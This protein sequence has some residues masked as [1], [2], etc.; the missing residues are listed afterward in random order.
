MKI[1]VIGYGGRG[2]LYTSILKDKHIEVEAICDTDKEKL[3]LAKRELSLPDGKLYADENEFFSKGKLVDILFVC[4]QDE[5]HYGHAIRAMK[6]GYDLLLEKPIAASVKQ[7]REIQQTAH[8]Y[9]RNVFVCHVLRYA[10]FF[11]NIK[12]QLARGKYGKVVTLSLTENVA[13]W[14][15][16]HS[17][18]RGN[19]RNDNFA[20]PM[21]IAKCCHDLD[22]ISWFTG[23]DCESVTSYGSLDYF[24]AKNAP[25]GSADRCL[26][27]KFADTCVYSAKKI[28][29]TDRAEKG[30]LQWP[31]D[32]VVNDPTVEKLYEALKTSEYGK[33]VYKCD[34]NV[35]DHQ[36]VN[37]K[38]KNNSTAQ[39]T[40]TAFSQD[41]YREIHV[42]CENGEIFG[43]MTDN[44]LHCNIFGKESF[45]V[46]ANIESDTAYGHGGGDVGM[47]NEI[48]NFYEGKK[49]EN[50]TSID[51]SMQ[52]HYMGFAAEE[53]R[54]NNGKVVKL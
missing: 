51:K 44:I 9:N 39:L 45:V 7:C 19:W 3:E 35:V 4:T 40:M 48:I 23:D 36:V 33:C 5:L 29:I 54:K 37:L 25:E 49:V 21:I 53:S 26:D 22:L 38:F 6:L 15:D 34:N 30:N 50:V 20:T 12:K 27:C 10:P 11:T 16:A 42:H 18:V 13:Y 46:D 47:I 28:Y 2:R 24:T 41:C 32:I 1:A 8:E 31:C 17:Y 14:H 43:N 52:S